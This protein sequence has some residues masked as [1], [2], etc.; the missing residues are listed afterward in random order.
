MK[1]KKRVAKTFYEKRGLAVPQAE[2]WPEDA[3]ELRELVVQ[4]NETPLIFVGDGQHLR[5]AVIGE[6]SYE[7]VR[8]SKC[9]RVI[10][11]D[12]ESK[13]ARVEAGITW[14]DLQAEL[15]ERGLSLERYQL[16]PPSATLGGLLGRHQQVG[17]EMW[18]GDLRGGCIALSTVT[19]ASGDFR[20][21]AAP[22]KASGPDQ[23]YMF[24][25]AEGLLGAILDVT[26]IGWKPSDARTFQWKVDTVEQA[27]QTYATAV[28]LGAQ[29][30]WAHLAGG[31][32][33]L[34]IH[35]SDR[36]L[37]G[38]EREFNAQLPGF[39][40]LGRDETKKLRNK[41][42][43]NHPDRRELATSKRTL[44][45]TFSLEHLATALGAVGN[46]ENI[47][48]WD[49]SRRSA[50]AFIRFSRGKTA[51][52]LPANAHALALASRPMV[53]D[54]TVHWPHWVQNLK[55]ELDPQRRLATGP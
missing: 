50:R 36:V 47:E 29:V 41:L 51:V 3:G 42:E 17:K 16:Y 34:A 7:V 19:P 37:R 46:A 30:S 8:T 54:E 43:A 44:T 20:Y 53:D 1:P 39:E 2:W 23:R 18:N 5:S 35:A 15:E 4:D 21:L 14:G 22:R 10:S 6:R 9:K 40:T 12:R 33:S 26:M 48:V 31:V 52:E 24:I 27:V 38:V 49:W 32:L 55:L 25:G 11:V 45:A 28:D 13:L